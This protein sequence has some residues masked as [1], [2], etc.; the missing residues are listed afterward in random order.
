MSTMFRKL[1]KE[2]FFI[3]RLFSQSQGYK[4]SSYFDYFK[5]RFFSQSILARLPRQTCSVNPALELHLICQESDLE[6]LQWSI[7]SF[8]HYSNLCPKIIIH[9]D[10]S[11]QKR[12]AQELENRFSN[13]K[14]LFRSEADRLIY[15]NVSIPEVVKTARKNGHPVLSQLTDV[16]LLSRAPIIMVMD[17]DVLFFNKPQELIDLI[18][19]RVHFDAMISRQYGSYDLEVSDDYLKKY[20]LIDKETGYMN[21]GFI[22]YKRSS[23]KTEQ[24]AEYFENS[25]R[26]SYS[27]FM[28]MAGWGCLIAQTNFKFLTPEKYIIKGRPN[29][30]TVMKHFTGP[31]RYELFAYGIDMA[32]REVVKR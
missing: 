6:M 16:F 10:G 21:P 7:R 2:A 18:E 25:T 4:L 3:K 24:L 30:Q 28:P 9:D 20:S 31:R 15:N 23:L 17:S 1:R 8:H 19:G 32:R 29:D 26:R 14:V 13:L 11:I 5:Y 12:S 27:F 22:I